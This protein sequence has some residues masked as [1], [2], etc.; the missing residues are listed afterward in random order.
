M[1]CR[2]STYHLR[3]GLG[4]ALALAIEVLI[5][6]ALAQAR[7]IECALPELQSLANFNSPFFA[8]TNRTALPV[9]IDA[10]PWVFASCIEPETA[11]DCELV[12]DNSDDIVQVQA[13]GLGPTCDDSFVR[14]QLVRFVPERQLLPAR[15]YTLR[16]ASTPLYAGWL[17]G[18]SDTITGP[19]NNLPLATKASTAPSLSPIDLTGTQATLRR[20]DDTCCARDPLY[21]EISVPETDDFKLFTRNG[22]LIEVLHEGDVWGITSAEDT[23]PMT[24]RGLVLTAVAADGS[25]GSPFEIEA[26]AI[27]EELIYTDF[28]CALGR[29]LNGSALWL[30]APFGFLLLSRRRAKR[31]AERGYGR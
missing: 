11:L 12:S 3:I 7:E 25:R 6:P 18:Y 31:R 20:R 15:R 2:R 4:A 29:R 13:E 27:D 28:D 14:P 5:G 23:L 9:P 17:S 1:S 21:L 24:E 10:H 8:G 30:L 16:C 26:S 19:V 22:G